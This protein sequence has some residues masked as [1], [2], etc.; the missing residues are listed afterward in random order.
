MHLIFAPYLWLTKCLG[1][2]EQPT[3]S[4][5][6]V[7]KQSAFFLSPFLFLPHHQKSDMA[8]FAARLHHLIVLALIVVGLLLKFT[9]L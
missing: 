5:L 6:L 1:V 7:S 2:Y 4:W 8:S 9:H 3:F